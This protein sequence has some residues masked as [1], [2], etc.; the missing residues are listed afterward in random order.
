[1]DNYFINE[2]RRSRKCPLFKAVAWLLGVL[3]PGLPRRTW[4]NHVEEMQYE[5][6]HQHERYLFGEAPSYLS[7]HPELGMRR[8]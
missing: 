1:M 3:C 7:L 5:L 8:G 4:A 2:I 6:D